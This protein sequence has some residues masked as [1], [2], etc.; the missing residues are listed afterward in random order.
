MALKIGGNLNSNTES[1][2]FKITVNQTTATT[3]LESL[4][5]DAP[6]RIKLDLYNNAETPVW[7][8]KKAAL[9][10]NEKTGIQVLPNETKNI[11]NS[12]S[13]YRGEVSAILDSGPDSTISGSLL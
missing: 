6:N 8:R 13:T 2:E 1:F 4:A 10:D 7:I 12:E 11:F 5:D 3:I 9:I